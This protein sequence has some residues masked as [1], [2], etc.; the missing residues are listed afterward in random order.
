MK[1]KE[2][3]KL[4]LSYE[5]SFIHENIYNFISAFRPVLRNLSLLYF[6]FF[7]RFVHNRKKKSKKIIPNINA[8]AIRIGTKE[9]VLF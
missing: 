9:K 1:K 6:S 4:I 7:H 5:Q 8:F 2:R 3:R